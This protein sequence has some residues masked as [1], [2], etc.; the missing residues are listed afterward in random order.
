M[1]GLRVGLTSLP[2]LFF[3][4]NRTKALNKNSVYNSKNNK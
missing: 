1:K 3:E 2:N 4:I